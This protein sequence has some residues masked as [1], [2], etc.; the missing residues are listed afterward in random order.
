MIRPLRSCHGMT[1]LDSFALCKTMSKTQRNF[2]SFFSSSFT[3]SP[4]S[5]PRRRSE[6]WSIQE[7]SRPSIP[8]RYRRNRRSF[9]LC[10]PRLRP[11]RPTRFIISRRPD[12]LTAAVATVVRLV[13]ITADR[14]GDD[15]PLHFISRMQQQKD[16]AKPEN[17]F[18]VTSCSDVETWRG[19]Q[20]AR[21]KASRSRHSL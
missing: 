15:N 17:H 3:P 1:S 13:Q 6:I 8:S 4:P 14:F 2:F 12:I 19:S 16:S 11:L 5:A 7:A 10:A 18:I 9:N 21:R 20:D